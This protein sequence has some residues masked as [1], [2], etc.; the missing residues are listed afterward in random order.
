[1]AHINCS[2]NNCHYWKQG[3]VCDA[4]E[5][6]ITADSIGAA[7]ADSFDAPQASAAPGTPVNHCM[8]TCCKTFCESGSTKKTQDGVYRR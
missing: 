1:M 4:S 2:V 3:N 5:I 8:E 6:M 7:M